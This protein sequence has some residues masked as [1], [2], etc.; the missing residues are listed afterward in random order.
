MIRIRA[1]ATAGLLLVFIVLFFGFYRN[2]LA[3]SSTVQVGAGFANAFAPQNLTVTQGDT[4]N[5]VW[6]SGFHNVTSGSCPG[7]NY[8]ADGKF[9]SGAATTPANTFGFA[10]NTPGTYSYFCSIHRAGMQGTI[11]VNAP[12]P[13][14]EVP[15]ADS[16][17]LILTGGAGLVSFLGLKW[18]GRK[19]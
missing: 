9:I 12:P 17:M 3:A 13:P 18:R 19:R 10:F 2:A 1:R 4:V 5:W 14:A 15:E 7:G 8:V 6:V 16:L 11:T